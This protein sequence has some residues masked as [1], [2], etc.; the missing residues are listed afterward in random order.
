MK[1]SCSKSLQNREL[2]R[3]ALYLCIAEYRARDHGKTDTLLD[4]VAPF[5]GISRRK[6]HT[7]YFNQT[8][9]AMGG[10]ERHRIRMGVARGLRD[11]ARR[12]RLW[13]SIM[14]AKADALE[15]AERQLSLEEWGPGN[16]QSDTNTF[17]ASSPSSVDGSDLAA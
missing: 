14:E 7:L 6:A 2:A 13:C 10:E 1:M 9:A 11:L 17:G 5:L 16:C 4:K 3:E 8:V 15:E 12:V